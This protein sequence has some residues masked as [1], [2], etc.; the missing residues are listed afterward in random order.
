MRGIILK[1]F[2]MKET[3]GKN[4]RARNELKDNRG[5]SKMTCSKAQFSGAQRAADEADG[6]LRG[7]TSQHQRV[8]R[9]C[10]VG[11]NYTRKKSGLKYGFH[12]GNNVKNF[13]RKGFLRGWLR[14]VGVGRELSGGARI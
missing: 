3:M 8:I 7:R 4:E 2:F 13:K 5:R 9:A 6:K 10:A 14:L 12:G 11:K 1:G